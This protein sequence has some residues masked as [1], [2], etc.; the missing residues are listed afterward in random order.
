MDKNTITLIQ[1]VNNKLPDYSFLIHLTDIYVPILLALVS[2]V[3]V[4]VYV[5]QGYRVKGNKILI[6]SVYLFF[7]FMI[8]DGILGVATIYQRNYHTTVSKVLR[9]L[10]FNDTSL[11]SFYKRHVLRGDDRYSFRNIYRIKSDLRAIVDGKEVYSYK[12]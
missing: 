2:L 8:T 11:S 1:E 6:Y 9:Q 12:K 5:R 3:F 4:W 7:F 10:P